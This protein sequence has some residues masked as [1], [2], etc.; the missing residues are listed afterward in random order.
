MPDVSTTALGTHFGVYEIDSRDGEVTEVRGHRLDPDPS[1]LGTALVDHTRNRVERPSVRKSWLEGGPGTATDLRGVEPFVEVEWDVALDLAASE[2]ARVRD[3]HGH[4]SIFGGSYGW[5]SAGRFH[6]SGPQTHRFLRL[7]GGYTDVRGTY[8]ASAAETVVPYVIG[9][10]YHQGIAEQTS[11]SVIAEHTEL[12]VTFGGFRLSNTQVTFGGQ[13]PHHTR[14]WMQTAVDGGMSLVNVSPLRDDLAA[15]FNPRWQPIRPCTDLALMIGLVHTL[16]DEGLADLEFLGTHCEGWDHFADY[17]HGRA[18]GVERNAQ[19]AADIT[20]IEADAIC[21]LAREMA[22]KRTLLNLSLSVQRADHGEQPY[23]MVFVLAAALGQIGLPGGGVGYPFGAQGNVGSG[24]RRARVPGLP[25]PPRPA[26]SAVISV[27]RVAELLEGPGVEFDFD[28]RRGTYPDIRLVYWAGGNPYHHH[29]DLNRLS[30]AW[31]KPETVIVHEPYWTPTARRADIVFPATTA[32][33]RNDLGGME[34]VLVA[35]A[36]AVEPYAESQDDY[37]IYSQLAQRLGFG[38]AFTEDRTA[39]EWIEV[40]YDLYRA[41]HPTVPSF[42][43]FWADGHLLHEGM[44]GMGESEQVFLADFRADPK[45]SPLPT[46]SG[47]LEVFSETVAEFGYDDCPGH[48]QWMEPYERL[49]GTGSDRWPLHLVSN[50]PAARLH[51]Q[52][53]HASLSRSTKVAGREPV[54]I[55]PS[56]AASRGISDGDVVRLFNDR[57]ACLAGAVIDDALMPEVVQ[58]S[59]GAWYDPDEQGVCRAG[60]PNVL[61]RDKGTSKLGQGPSAHSCLIEIELFK[62]APPPVTAHEPPQIIRSETPNDPE[63]QT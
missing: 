10:G 55:H 56:I 30:L 53:D 5:G 36:R 13:G 51:S 7:F 43:D 9:K 59:T 27:S 19:W 40:L 16:V 32:L 39:D 62:D 17:V 18:D 25:L 26:D 15:E 58:L 28:G 3:Q 2:L 63:V 14:R 23:W 31:Q 44:T 37:W 48:P 34:T 49:G 1:P 41:E 57:G 12:M 46:P 38:P 50:Q 22:S 33:E 42:D 54:R 60:N 11:W 45:A 52:M 24:Q 29:Q 61:T 35:M 47:R 4:T 6:M 21:D 8:S 20:G